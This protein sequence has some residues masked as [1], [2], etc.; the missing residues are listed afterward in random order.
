MPAMMKAISV[1]VPWNWYLLYVGKDIENRSLH[2]PHSY[3]GRVLLHVSKWWNKNK[4][5]RDIELANQMHAKQPYSFMNAP[6]LTLPYLQSTCGNIIGSI[7]IDDYVEQTSSPWYTGKLGLVIRDPIAFAEPIPYRGMLGLFS[8]DAFSAQFDRCLLRKSP[9][10]SQQACSRR[11]KVICASEDHRM[12]NQYTVLNE[13]AFDRVEK[14]LTAMGYHYDFA[15]TYSTKQP[16]DF[17][18]T[19]KET[20]WEMRRK[21][22]SWCATHSIRDYKIVRNTGYVHDLHGPAVYELWVRK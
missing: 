12:G 9:C 7:Q 22:K 6:A 19:G 16:S 18:W 10:N 21:L 8:V 20:G 5:L 14:K 17:Y 3:R 2:F 11:Q 15:C 13:C 1:R 4:I